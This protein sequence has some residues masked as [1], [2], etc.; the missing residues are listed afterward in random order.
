MGSPYKKYRLFNRIV[1]RTN[2]DPYTPTN[3]SRT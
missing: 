2:A 3:R 1:R